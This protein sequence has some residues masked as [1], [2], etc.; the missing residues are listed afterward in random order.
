MDAADARDLVDAF[1]RVFGG[2]LVRI[3]CAFEGPF[4]DPRGE[5]PV[6]VVLSSFPGDADDFGL[7]IDFCPPPHL[8]CDLLD[9][10]SV[11]LVHQQ[12]GEKDLPVVVEGSVVKIPANGRVV[13]NGLEDGNYRIVFNP[14]GT[15]I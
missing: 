7:R 2:R 9:G 8:S 3:P 6:S 5:M 12:G 4:Y 10:C 13:I 11:F 1:C 15:C 14:D